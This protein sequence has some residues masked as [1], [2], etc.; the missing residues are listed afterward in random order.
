[1]INYNA[2]V[3]GSYSLFIIVARYLLLVHLFVHCLIFIRSLFDFLFHCSLFIVQ[4]K[5]FVS[6]PGSYSRNFDPAVPILQEYHH[7]LCKSI[8][9]QT[10]PTFS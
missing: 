8:N 5:R 2:H 10:A 4:K 1:M 6:D 7:H 9:I 3:P